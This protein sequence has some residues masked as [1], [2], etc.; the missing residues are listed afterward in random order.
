[1]F[2]YGIADTWLDRQYNK[3]YRNIT[4]PGEAWKVRYFDASWNVTWQN[5]TNT[6]PTSIGQTTGPRRP[7]C[8]QLETGSW[9]IAYNCDTTVP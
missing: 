4:Y 2:A 5:V 3:A 6:S 9:M 7:D 1:V 8:N